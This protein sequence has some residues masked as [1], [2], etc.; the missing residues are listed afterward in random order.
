MRVL[1][2]LNKVFLA[3]NSRLQKKTPGRQPR[4][5]WAIIHRETI[6]IGINGKA[7]GFLS[8]GWT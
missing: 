1:A 5:L 7:E 6:F 8:A 4:C 3:G 2:D